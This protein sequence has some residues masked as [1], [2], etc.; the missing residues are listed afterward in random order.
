MRCAESEG[1]ICARS[2]GAPCFH[3]CL[4][5]CP[6]GTSTLRALRSSRIICCGNTGSRALRAAA[7]SSFTITKEMKFLP[8]LVLLACIAAAVAVTHMPA[9]PDVDDEKYSEERASSNDVELQDGHALLGDAASMDVEEATNPSSTPTYT[10]VQSTGVFSGKGKDGTLISV[11]G[12]AGSTQPKLPLFPSGC[13]NVPTC[14]CIPDHGPLPKNTLAPPP[15]PP[16]CTRHADSH[17]HPSLSDTP[18]ANRSPIPVQ[19]GPLTPIPSGVC[20]CLSASRYVSVFEAVHDNAFRLDPGSANMCSRSG[21]L[22]HG[23]TCGVNDPSHV[24]T[25]RS[26]RKARSGWL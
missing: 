21:F 11:T 23:G 13:V 16:F 25:A 14:Q 15:T 2:A 9:L 10:Y 24:N 5:P 12:C 1:N 22:I 8:V 4:H 7:A 26:I 17:T 20:V 3:P 18:L 6:A 19:V